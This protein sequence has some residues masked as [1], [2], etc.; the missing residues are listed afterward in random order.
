MTTTQFKKILFKGVII[1]L[2][3]I[4]YMVIIDLFFSDIVFSIHHHMFNISR[5]TFNNMMY[6]FIGGFKIIWLV[7]F[8]IPYIAIIWSEKKGEL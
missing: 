8:V 7:T 2:G 3:I 6:M 4:G 1:G 5:E